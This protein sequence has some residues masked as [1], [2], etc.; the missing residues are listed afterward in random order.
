ME[1]LPVNTAVSGDI[2]G[3][4]RSELEAIDEPLM[5]DVENEEACDSRLVWT[6]LGRSCFCCIGIMDI[7]VSEL[8]SEC[9]VKGLKDMIGSE[10]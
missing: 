2:M 1:E 3:E 7:L 8:E 4:P 6:V 5:A 10:V 9:W